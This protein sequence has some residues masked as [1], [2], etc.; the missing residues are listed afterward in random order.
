MPAYRFVALVS[1][2]AMPVMAQ[3][4][5]PARPVLIRGAIVVDGSGGP[6]RVADVRIAGGTIQRIGQLAPSAGDS[7]VEAR[8]L[9]L[10]PGFIDTHSH[11]SGGLDREPTALGAVSQGITTIIV[12]QDGG[13]YFPLADWFARREQRPAAVNVAS[14]VGHGTL[15]D[16]I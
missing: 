8:G 7:I 12:G 11:H 1:S 4:P 9:V 15:R 16:R 5:A 14:Y 10:A 6:S 2:L 3:Q 13:S